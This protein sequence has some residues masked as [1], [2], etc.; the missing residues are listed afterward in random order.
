MRPQPGAFE[1]EMTDVMMEKWY[2][3]IRVF[4]L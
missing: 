2:C 3:V 4:V 1:I